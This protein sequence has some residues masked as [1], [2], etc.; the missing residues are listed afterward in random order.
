M[1]RKSQIN[2]LNI[3]REDVENEN[4]IDTLYGQECALQNKI[5]AA[6]FILT[7]KEYVRDKYNQ[8]SVGARIAKPTL[9]I[10]GIAFVLFW[11]M[12]F[13]GPSY[14][15]MGVIIADMAVFTITP[16]AA[17]IIWIIVRS[18]SIKRL[19]INFVNEYIPLRN[20]I[21]AEGK[22][23]QLEIVDVKKRIAIQEKKYH[24][25][26]ELRPHMEKLIEY[27]ENA[28][29]NTLEEAVSLLLKEIR[30]REEIEELK[31][32][33][34]EAKEAKYAALDEWAEMREARAAAEREENAAWWLDLDESLRY[35]NRS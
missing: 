31:K 35:Y 30:Q 20:K 21:E 14:D 25:P 3:I 4:Q 2:W 9:C 6:G 1:G 34:D 11:I 19:R 32:Q 17:I 13:S 23:A 15:T 33:L 18:G 26:K 10:M 16:I 29:A 7:E 28:R 22:Q 8:L 27:F 5:D 12:M 24:L